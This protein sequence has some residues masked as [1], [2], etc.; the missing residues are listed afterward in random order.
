MKKLLAL[1]WLLL[2]RYGS[3]V[4]SFVPP[5]AVREGRPRCLMF[6]DS[7][8]AER[9]D[10]DD[11]GNKIDS[12]SCNRRN[13]FQRV[14]TTSTTMTLLLTSSSSSLPAHARGLVSFPCTGPLLNIYHIMRAGTSLLEE[15]DIWSTNP[16]FL[17]NREAALSET[18]VAQVQAACKI[19]QAADINPS[20]MKY[21]LAA[22]AVD[23][24]MVIRD[25]LKVGQNRLIPE[26]TFMDPRAIGKWDTM[27]FAETFPAVV[28][29]DELEAGK[30]GKGG[31]PPANTDGT[32]QDTLEDQAIRLRQLMSSTYCKRWMTTVSINV[33]FRFSFLALSI[34]LWLSTIHSF[35]NTIFRG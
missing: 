28:A 25:E 12:A 8:S 7:N 20:V 2:H 14:V 9:L 4:T 32:P 1:L 23:T 31:L 21:S 13:F 11:D 29:L 18:G 27:S 15:E 17:T 35:G 16:L 10:D 19:L 26:F 3:Q 33:L 34:I 5:I 24:A 6:F 30:D 22:S